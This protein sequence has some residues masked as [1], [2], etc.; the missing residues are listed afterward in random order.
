MPDRI[1]QTIERIRKTL[2][3]ASNAKVTGKISYEI[4]MSQGGIGRAKIRMEN[5]LLGEEITQ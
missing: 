2:S 3:D 1:T 4:D 5:D